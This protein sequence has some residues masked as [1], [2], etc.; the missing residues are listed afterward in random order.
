MSKS[1]GNA[2]SSYDATKFIDEL[3][4]AGDLINAK[5]LRIDII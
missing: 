2:Y 1:Y 3:I 5:A 4:Y